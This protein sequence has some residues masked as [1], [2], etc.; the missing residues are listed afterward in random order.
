MKVS[1]FEMDAGAGEPRNP[2]YREPEPRVAMSA[3]AAEGD[4][5]EPREEPE[6]PGYGHGV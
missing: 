5:E 1:P 3:A 4:D 2:P 6:E